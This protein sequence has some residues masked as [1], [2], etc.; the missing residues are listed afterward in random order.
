MILANV[1]RLP[2][3]ELYFHTFNMD[4][5]L[6]VLLHRISTFEWILFVL[7]IIQILP[8]VLNSAQLLHCLHIQ[9]VLLQSI[10]I[11]K[12]FW[13]III[14]TLLKFQLFFYHFGIINFISL[15][16][17]KDLPGS[18]NITYASFCYAVFSYCANSLKWTQ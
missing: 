14:A 3:L 7:L 10:I 13:N 15:N 5:S 6:C 17:H 12:I 11:F 8:I 2:F 9:H 4:D 1:I 18:R 16:K